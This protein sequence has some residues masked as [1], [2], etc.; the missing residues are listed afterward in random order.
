VIAGPFLQLVPLRVSMLFPLEILFPFLNKTWLIARL[1]M[2]NNGCDGG[3]MDDAFKYIIA[4]GG[5]DTEASYPYKG[6]TGTCEFNSANVGATLSGYTDVTSGSE[7]ALQTAVVQQPVSVAIDASHNSF[8]LY[9]SG[10]YYEPSCSTSALDHGVL[11]IGYGTSGSSDYW[12]VKNSWGTSWGISGYIWMSRNKDNNCGIATAA[13]YP[14]TSSS[15]GKTTTTSKT[16]TSA[17][18]TTAAHSTAS[19][20]TSSSTYAAGLEGF[21]PANGGRGFKPFK[22]QTEKFHF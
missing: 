8:Q 19:H 9:T 5:V 2:E 18:H 16:H 21:K 7:S 22:D 12:L 10:V 20:S 14:T 6:V 15:T 1:A 11:A 17:T 3:L 4:N 13:S